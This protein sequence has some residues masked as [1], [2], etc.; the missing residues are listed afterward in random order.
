MNQFLLKNIDIV[1]LNSLNTQKPNYA[2][3][4]SKQ[5]VAVG[6]INLEDESGHEIAELCV[7]DLLKNF[8]GNDW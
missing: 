6:I 5:F 7:R 4:E 2:G 1:M 8:N 3:A